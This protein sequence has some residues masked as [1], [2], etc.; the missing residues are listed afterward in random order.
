MFGITWMS[1]GE[2]WFEISIKILEMRDEVN[3]RMN[4]CLGWSK[5]IEATMNY[6]VESFL[7]LGDRLLVI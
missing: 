7:L 4:R 6:C 1:D 3:D 5:S 2:F